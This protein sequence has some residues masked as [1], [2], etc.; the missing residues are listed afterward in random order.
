VRF[1]S[2]KATEGTSDQHSNYGRILTNARDAG[3]PVLGAYHVVR[4][5][6]SADAQVAYMLAYLDQATPWWRQ[7][8]H[9]FLQVDLERWPYDQVSAAAGVAFATALRRATGH[10]V[11]IYASRGQYGNTIPPGFD[12]W[13][14]NYPSG[15]AAHYPDLYPGDNGVGWAAYSGRAPVL[16]QY[17]SSGTV[18]SQP[19][20]DVNAYRGSLD[21]LL[22]LTA[23]LNKGVL[24]AL[25]DLQQIQMFNRVEAILKGLDSQTDNGAGGYATEP[26][27]TMAALK[28]LS[29]Q[30]A[31]LAAQPAIVTLSPDQLATITQAIINHPDTPLGDADK[32]AIEA[33]VAAAFARAFPASA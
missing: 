14:A 18:G 28:A 12:L 10:Y 22:A 21:Q 19:G 30:V 3:V 15:R 16:W 6:P 2:H 7:H 29:A 23:G 4:S 1:L 33:A 24:M 26:N 32:P 17:T 8:P 31:A 13:N 11:V 5:G 9:F 27:G 25:S 20:C